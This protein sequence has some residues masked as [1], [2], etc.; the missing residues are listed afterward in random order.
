[1]YS[2]GQ[3][4]MG[5]PAAQMWRF[6]WLE[7][8]VGMSSVLSLNTKLN[9]SFQLSMV[10]KEAAAARAC[11]VLNHCCHLVHLLP[12]LGI[13]NHAS[14]WAGNGAGYIVVLI[15]PHGQFWPI[16]LPQYGHGHKW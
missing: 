14:K 11:C 9:E 15:W 13:P 3:L 10:A 7:W 4:N 6:M 5:F 8:S 12:W 1:M 2:H 16:K